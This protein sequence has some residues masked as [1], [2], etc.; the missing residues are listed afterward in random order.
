MACVR[1]DVEALACVQA[2]ILAFLEEAERTVREDRELQ[3]Q[4]R[5]T[6]GEVQRFKGHIDAMS[7]D[8][9]RTAL[10]RL[11]EGLWNDLARELDDT[12][13]PPPGPPRRGEW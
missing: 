13:R 6:A 1:G 5:W 2:R 4:L 3:E 10:T 7:L 12:S 11:A 9:I 8:H